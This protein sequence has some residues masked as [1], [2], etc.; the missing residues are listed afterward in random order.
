VPLGTSA[1]FCH[2][3]KD[4]NEM[5]GH[6]EP[7][8]KQTDNECRTRV[9][10][11]RATAL[12]VVVIGIGRLAFGCGGSSPKS[13]GPGPSPAQAV[14][15]AVEFSV[16]M[17]S[18]GVPDFPDPQI[19]GSGGGVQAKITVTAHG[20]AAGG[21]NPNSPAFKTAQQACRKLLPNGGSPSGGGANGAQ[22]QSQALKLAGCMRAQG[23]RDFPDPGPGGTFNLPSDIDQQAPGF[24]SALQACTWGRGRSWPRTPA[25]RPGHARAREH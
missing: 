22:Q 2:H 10:I 1:G 18:H 8:T 15:K 5:S 11:R 17:R 6:R 25:T 21:L 3:P 14:K 16:C 9:P 7:G 19:S 23:V 13:S 4:V 24:K 20:G 12:A